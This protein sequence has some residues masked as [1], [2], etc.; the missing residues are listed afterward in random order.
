[1]PETLTLSEPE[2]VALRSLVASGL[3]V[4]EVAKRLGYSKKTTRRAYDAAG[5]TPKQVEWTPAEV[6]RLAEVWP[7]KTRE[8]IEEAFPGRS[9]ATIRR[10]AH[11]LGFTTP[12][13][14]SRRSASSPEPVPGAGRTGPSSLRSAPTNS[15]AGTVA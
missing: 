6:D 9:F 14:L 11:R 8:Q 12:R 13:H 7:T 2:L 4:I 15:H 10:K 1:M 5:V 3:S